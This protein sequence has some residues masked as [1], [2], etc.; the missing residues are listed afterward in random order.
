MSPHTG[1]LYYNYK[2][3]N[4]IVPMA[5]LYINLKFIVIDL[6]AYGRQSDGV[7]FTNSRFGQALENGL[8]CLPPPQR[9]PNDTTIAPHVFVGDEAFQLRSDFPR[10]YPRN[11]LEDDE[12]IQLSPEPR[13]VI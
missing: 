4:S 12:N 9:L 13:K 7:T 8:L 11:R 3:I 5:V 6:G 1:S 10:P 2:G